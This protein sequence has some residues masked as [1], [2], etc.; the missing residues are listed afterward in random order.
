MPGYIAVVVHV[1]S[2]FWLVA[3]IVGRDVC[4]RHAARAADFAALRQI[5]L[6]ASFFE[7]R[8]VQ[9]ATLVV[10]LTG[11][12]AA[13]LRGHRI[14][15]FLRGEGPTWPFVALLIYLSIIPV[16]VFLFVPKGRA[17]RAA[18]AEAEGSGEV[19]ARLRAAIADPAVGA[20]R[21]Y[22]FVMI[23]VLVYLMV[24]KPF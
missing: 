14:F 17:Y 23:T 19:T 7:R 15:G 21:G 12:T 18:L 2:V 4:W 22:E 9:P 8:M 10:L 11:L 3:G 5:A 20:G 16:I 13:G 6:L 1:L 24:T